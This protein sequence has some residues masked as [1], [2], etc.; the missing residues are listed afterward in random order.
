MCQRYT[1][2]VPPTRAFALTGHACLPEVVS[3]QG[4]ASAVSLMMPG[5]RPV[6]AALLMGSLKGLSPLSGPS[7]LGNENA[8][9]DNAHM[10]GVMFSFESFV[11]LTGI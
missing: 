4:V 10:H 11:I 6:F 5:I 2:L 3:P 9:V 7:T 1:R 8:A